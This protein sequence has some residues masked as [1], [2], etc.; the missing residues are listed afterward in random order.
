MVQFNSLLLIFL[1]AYLLRFGIQYSLN[2]LNH[3]YL[4]Q[5]GFTVPEVF[6]GVV[7]PE[8]LR[9][10]SAYTMDTDRFLMIETVTNQALVLTVLLLGLL[11]WFV[12]IINSWNDGLIL[13]GLIFF[14]AL[15]I[16]VN[17]FRIPFSLYD[18]FVIENRYG[19]N[20]ITL[21]IWISDLLKSFAISTLLGG[22]LLWLLLFLMV[23]GGTLWWVWAWLFVGGFEL[24]MLWLFPVA[25]APLF[26]KFEPIDNPTTI[27]MI[28]SRQWPVYV[29]GV[30][31]K[32]DG[33]SSVSMKQV[34]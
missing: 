32:L 2:R 13:N 12:K 27:H 8:K 19:F 7:D 23:Q 30:R 29:S 14:A 33:S 26:N 9:K 11:P 10:I 5:H 31:D 18:T 25:I 6:Q 28:S 4:R 34:Q 22:L 20:V 16:L 3:S 21:R 24:L 17:L 15:S 1:G